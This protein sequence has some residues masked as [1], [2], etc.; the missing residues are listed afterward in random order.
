[1]SAFRVFAGIMAFIAAVSLSGCGRGKQNASLA[2][3]EARLNVASARSAGAQE[4]VAGTMRSAEDALAAAEKAFT[5][6]S[7]EEA[8]VTAAKAARLAA[9]AQAEAE[10]KA[11]E[12]KKK[13]AKKTA[14]GK[15]AGPAKKNK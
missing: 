10:R 14:S 12:K 3:D 15:K 4:H 2:L 7:F 1:M 8:R 6:G 11:A 5:G 9:A 13:P